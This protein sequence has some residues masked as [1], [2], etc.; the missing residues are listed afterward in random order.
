MAADDQN[1]SKCLSVFGL[2]FNTSEGELSEEFFR[3]GLLEKVDIIHDTDSG[4]STGFA[5]TYLETEEGFYLV[6]LH[7]SQLYVN[8]LKL[9]FGESQLTR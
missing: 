5:F 3:L 9:A 4:S 6:T 7:H 8:N 1:G 2:H